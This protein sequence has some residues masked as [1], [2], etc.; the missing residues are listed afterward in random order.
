MQTFLAGIITNSENNVP[1]NG[2]TVTSDG[3]TYTT[4]TWE[5]VFNKYT[6]HP[7]LTHNGFYLFQGSDPG[8][9]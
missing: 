7:D 5:S 8:T 1:I 2:V 3:K 6:N 9:Q 4:D